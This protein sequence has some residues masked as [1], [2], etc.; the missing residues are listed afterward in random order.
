MLYRVD[1]VC[2]NDESLLLQWEHDIPCHVEGERGFELY[3]RET[4]SMEDITSPESH[5]HP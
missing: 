3:A 5:N 2:Q 4:L 1:Q